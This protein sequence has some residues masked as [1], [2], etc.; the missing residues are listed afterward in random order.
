M[1]LKNEKDKVR[2]MLA[3]TPLSAEKIRMS[4]QD[5]GG[6]WYGTSWF[7]LMHII[8]KAL[9]RNDLI[10]FEG[11]HTT[12]KD[13]GITKWEDRDTLEKRLN[14]I[15][16]IFRKRGLKNIYVD[17]NKNLRIDGPISKGELYEFTQSQYD[18]SMTDG[19]VQYDEI[20]EQF[21]PRGIFSYAE[22][23]FW[24][25]ITGVYDCPKLYES[26]Q[27]D[28][29]TAVTNNVFDNMEDKYESQGVKL[30]E[31]H[32]LTHVRSYLKIWERSLVSKNILYPLEFGG[33]LF[34]SPSFYSEIDFSVFKENEDK[35]SILK[36]IYKLRKFPGCPIYKGN[37]TEYDLAKR[38]Q[39]AGAVK[40][41]E[42]EP[43]LSNHYVYLVSRDI[44]NE[45][46]KKIR[47]NY[48]ENPLSEF[49]DSSLTQ[50]IFVV[51]GRS[52]LLSE[53]KLP[54]IQ[55]TNVDYQIEIERILG[56]LENKSES[57]LGPLEG[58]GLFDPFLPL[59]IV[60]I[61]GDNIHMESDFD[62]VIKE[63]SDYYF[64]LVNDPDIARIDFPPRESIQKI[65]KE[66]TRRRIEEKAKSFF[67]N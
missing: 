62:W 65:E 64:S 29:L 54:Q 33:N 1:Y 18:Y 2:A 26:S 45:L 22:R 51:L 17:R 37:A 24:H 12:V 58:V 8:A 21:R 57:S 16:D 59:N 35:E 4:G 6:N 53:G 48:S 15:T 11:L 10:T 50:D 5:L 52:R 49:G 41:V 42:E 23:V 30:W 25:Y 43:S 34:I 66:Q 32:N 14:Q 46:D 27:G 19:L 7:F 28:F 63:I 47:F 9:S 60:R 39:R 20:D 13:Y 44:F 3:G 61:E 31:K 56:E 67:K 38:L 55:F 36:L 40:I